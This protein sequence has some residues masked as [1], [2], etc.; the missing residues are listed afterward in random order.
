MSYRQIDHEAQLRERDAT[1]AQLRAENARLCRAL[2]P[3]PPKP[4]AKSTVL[5]AAN[6][7]VACVLILAGFAIV[8]FTITAHPTRPPQPVF[9]SRPAADSVPVVSID[10]QTHAIQF[11]VAGDAVIAVPAN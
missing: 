4:V 3:K 5:D 11:H 9:I 7:A 6:F 10:N 2:E 8:M 1:I